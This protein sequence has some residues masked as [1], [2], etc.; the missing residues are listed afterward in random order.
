MNLHQ[1]PTLDN[2]TTAARTP[3]AGAGHERAAWSA[4]WRTA[5]ARYRRSGRFAYHFARGKLRHDPVF[6]ALLARGDIAPNARVL[7][8][9]C[10]QGLL[11]SLLAA[12]EALAARGSWPARWPPAPTGTHYRGIELMARDVAR[13]DTALHGLPRSPRVQRGDMRTTPFD[14]CDVVVILDVLHYVDIREQDDVLARVHAALAPGG[15]LLLRVGDAGARWRHALTR[16]VDRAVTLVRGHAAP[17]VADRT[18][19]QWTAALQHL[20]FTVQVRPMYQGTPFANMLLVCVKA[21]AGP[22]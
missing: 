6:Q 11:A 17:P 14:A 10:G 21:P 5:A 15:R 22:A 3:T 18:L 20:G 2:R 13:A 9:G 4:L 16:W 12:G 1:V 19:A 8:I 7:D